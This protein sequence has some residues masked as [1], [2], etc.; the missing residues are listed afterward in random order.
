MEKE[1]N[2]DINNTY[3]KVKSKQHGK[4][5]LNYYKK[6]GYINIIPSNNKNILDFLE[7]DLYIVSCINKQEFFE[8]DPQL[9][10]NEGCVYF[11]KFKPCDCKEDYLNFYQ[12]IEL[13]EEIE[14]NIDDR[15]STTKENINFL[16]NQNK[17]IFKM[18][19][20][21]DERF[22]ELEMKN[23]KILEQLLEEIE[24]LKNK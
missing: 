2:K 3:I 10:L 19:C 22:Y 6:N 9:F 23:I 17:R 11:S 1:I 15:K 20:S 4:D 18:E 24:M 13:K 8:L 5:I 21:M 12:N 16:K 14:K 7:K